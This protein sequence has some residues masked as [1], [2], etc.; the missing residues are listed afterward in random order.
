M[1]KLCVTFVQSLLFKIKGVSYIFAE[2]LKLITEDCIKSLFYLKVRLATAH[3]AVLSSINIQREQL[4]KAC[5]VSSLQ[6]QVESLEAE[7][8][9]LEKKHRYLQQF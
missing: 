4:E 5:V 9:E 3:D 8:V 6:E 7:K 2:K 1:D